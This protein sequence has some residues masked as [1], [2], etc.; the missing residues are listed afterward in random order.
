MKKF[1]TAGLITAS[2]LIALTAYTL[3]MNPVG[4]KVVAVAWTAF[5]AMTVGT[6]LSFYHLKSTKSVIWAYG[7][8]GGAALASVMFFI[9]P[10]SLQ[11]SKNF[12]ITGVLTGFLSGLVLHAVTHEIEHGA[13]EALSDL[14]SITAHAA[15]AGLIIGRIYSDLP[16]VSIILGVSIVSHKLPAGYI[17]SD[18]LEGSMAK[19]MQFILLPATVLGS[20]ALLVFNLSLKM[21]VNIQALFFGFSA[22]IFLHLALDFI[23][24]PEPESHLRKLLSEEEDPLHHKIDDIK[25]HCVASTV[26]GAAV[27]TTLALIL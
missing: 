11:M 13:G 3:L 6:A 8:S 14:L 20:M 10:K 16:G 4:V 1:E 12:G 9:L 26:L 18:K 5:F 2:V 23:P 7:L 27:V 19:V 15:A 24:E 21:P 17:I 22:G 25:F